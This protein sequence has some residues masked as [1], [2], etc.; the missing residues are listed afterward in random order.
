MRSDYEIT[1]KS[2]K[3]GCDTEGGTLHLLTI[4]SDY[5]LRIQLKPAVLPRD[6]FIEA[7]GNYRVR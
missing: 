5:G 2:V 7:P 6:P 3:S 1:T 4:K